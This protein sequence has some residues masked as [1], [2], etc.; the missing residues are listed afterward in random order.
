MKHPG[1]MTRWRRRLGVLLVAASLAIAGL[2]LRRWRLEHLGAPIPIRAGLVMGPAIARGLAQPAPPRPAA[3]M[4]TRDP[5]GDANGGV[6]TPT[7]AELARARQA[8]ADELRALA[9]GPIGRVPTTSG[10]GFTLGMRGASVALVWPPAD[11]GFALRCT[12]AP[13]RMP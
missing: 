9:P 4:V 12:D 8:I 13:A 1:S 6:R 5:V 7:A 11:G 3:A 10:V 2:A